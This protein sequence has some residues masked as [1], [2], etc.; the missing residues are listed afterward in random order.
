[1]YFYAEKNSKDVVFSVSSLAGNMD[2]YER[3][4]NIDSCDHQYLGCLHRNGV[5]YM[6]HATI[7]KLILA[8]SETG[9]IDVTWKDLDGNIVDETEGVRVK[10]NGEEQIIHMIDGQGSIDFSSA[11]T[12]THVLTVVG[13]SGC[14]STLTVE[15]V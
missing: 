9:T 2:A 8:V 6:L 3:L 11:N 1:M 10:C 13:D 14:Y 5:F 15:V 4:V 12:G 7:N